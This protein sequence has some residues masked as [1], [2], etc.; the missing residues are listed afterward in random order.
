VRLVALGSRKLSYVLGVVGFVGAQML[1]FMLAGRLSA[2]ETTNSTTA[3]FV[4]II[5]TSEYD[6]E[7]SA[8]LIVLLV[9]QRNASL[10]ASICGICT[11]FAS[12]K[13]GAAKLF[14][15]IACHS[16]RTPHSLA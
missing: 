14:E 13:R 8:P 11:S 16:Y 7:R 5:G 3:V 10:L 12:S 2:T 9:D 4:A 15:S 6:R 1:F